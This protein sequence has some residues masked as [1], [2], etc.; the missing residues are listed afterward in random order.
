[1]AIT[2]CKVVVT[3]G[4]GFIGS[5]I[6]D[7]LLASGNRVTVIDNLS[8]G[9]VNN[10]QH[11]L[12]AGNPSLEFIRGS[13]TDLSLLQ[14]AFKNA[15]YVFHQAAIPSVPRSVANPSDSND[16]NIT[17][18]LNVL[19]AARDNRVKKVVYASSCSVYGDTP[20]LP[21]QEDMLPCP[22]SPYAV[23]KLAG[24]YYCRVFNTVYNLPTVSLRYF[25]VY[26]PRQDPKSEYAAVIPRFIDLVRQGRPPVVFGDGE[27]T[28]DFTFVKDVVSANLFFAES[29]V[30]G[31]FNIGCGESITLNRLVGLI[32]R[33]WGKG[34]I[35]PE[36]A[37][38][39]AGDIRHSL[40]DISRAR[41]AGWHPQYDII[42]GLEEMDG[43]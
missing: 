29:R 8:T 21:K 38:P 35:N 40:A 18:T 32:I 31:V 12:S 27:Q 4:A 11:H 36:Y 13:I 43:R 6:V 28:R 3:G 9:N 34:E 37:S 1:M 15:D 25:N 19:I 10:I 26:G 39:R 16:V 14:K 33:I 24:E 42:A 17:G 23:S 22:L 41:A 5:H 20:T 2:G 7:A 30:T